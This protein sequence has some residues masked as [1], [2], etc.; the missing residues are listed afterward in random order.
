MK[1]DKLI[2][3]ITIF[4]ILFCSLSITY[5]YYVAVE[6]TNSIITFGNVKLKLIEKELKNGTYIDIDDNDSIDI[7]N[8]TKLDRM[9]KVKNVGSNPFYLRLKIDFNS[10]SNTNDAVIILPNENWKYEN[11]YYY[12]EN[13]VYPNEETNEL[14]NEIAFNK[15]KI[16][17]NYNGN[18]FYLKIT[19]QAVQSEHNMNDVMEVTNWP[20]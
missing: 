2:L 17:E 7:T 13:I 18:K 11:G 16:L 9:V 4:I 19:A 3:K 10:T 14:M 8:I 15:Q 20:N 5:A 12:Y 6:D 1:K